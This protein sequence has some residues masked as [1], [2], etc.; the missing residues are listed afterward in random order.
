LTLNSELRTLNPQPYIHA[1]QVV[2]IK[3]WRLKYAP[4][5]WRTRP[6]PES[7]THGLVPSAAAA[8]AACLRGFE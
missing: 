5:S 1:H 2:R 3:H 8:A 4:A 6:R 7:G